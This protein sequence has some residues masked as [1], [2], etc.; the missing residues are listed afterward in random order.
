MITNAATLLQKLMA[1]EAEKL[2]SLGIRHAPTIGAM[3]EGLAK[4]ILDRTIPPALGV[5]VVDGFIRGYDGQLSRQTDCMVVVGDGEKL[6]YLDAYVWPIQNVIAVAEVKK[7]LFGDDLRDGFQKLREIQDIQRAYVQH[8]EVGKRVSIDPALKAFAILTGQFPGDKD[9]IDA[10]PEDLN[11]ILHTLVMEQV[12]PVRVI[13]GYDGYATESSL[14]FGFHKYLESNCGIRG[15]GVGSLPNLL[16]CNKNSILKLNGFP[17]VARKTDEWWDVLVSNSEN[18]VRLLIELLWARLANH[19]QAQFPSD[20]NLELERLAPFLSA[21]FQLSGPNVGWQY[22]YHEVAPDK[23]GNVPSIQW[24]P[25]P[26]EGPVWV[27]LMR[28]LEDG[29]LDIRDEGFREYAAKEGFDPDV[30]IREMVEHRLIAWTGEYTV[31]PIAEDLVTIFM[32]DG[33]VF[34]S[35]DALIEPWVMEALSKRRRT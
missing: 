12:S 28:A 6:P 20:D 2:N 17:Y 22:I 29:E 1:K 26:A 19:F 25:H 13:L 32:P 21:K 27:A 30:V 15:F 31:T 14:R 10:L 24:H 7:S 3:Y 9:A 4:D 8:G 5:R 18:P 35:D 33:R 16:I 34:V 23:L 11:V